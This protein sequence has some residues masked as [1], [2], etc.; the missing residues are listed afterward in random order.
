MKTEINCIDNINLLKSQKS[1]SR[2][3]DFQKSE[4]TK[5]WSKERSKRGAN[6]MKKKAFINKIN[7]IKPNETKNPYIKEKGFGN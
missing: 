2:K 4:R 1:E 5:I 7:W 6:A 3:I